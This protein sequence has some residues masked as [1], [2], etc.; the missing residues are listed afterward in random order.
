[1]IVTHEKWSIILYVIAISTKKTKDWIFKRVT[2]IPKVKI[3]LYKHFEEKLL[4]K[5]EKVHSKLS[6]SLNK[7]GYSVLIS[8]QES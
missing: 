5:S 8:L 2:A 7:M 4:L 1:M 6:I 3:S